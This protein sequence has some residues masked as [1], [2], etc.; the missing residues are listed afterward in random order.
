VS[1]GTGAAPTRDTPADFER[2]VVA[3]DRDELEHTIA[4]LWDELARRTGIG[5]DDPRPRAG[6]VRALPPHYRLRIWLDT[7]P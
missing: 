1:A 3:R 4:G 7:D 5:H 2:D 6:I